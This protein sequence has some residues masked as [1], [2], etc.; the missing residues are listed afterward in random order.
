MFGLLFTSWILLAIGI[1]GEYMARMVIDTKGRPVYII[2]EEI[3]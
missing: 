2:E 1:I 3:R